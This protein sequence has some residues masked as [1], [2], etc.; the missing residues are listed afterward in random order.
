MYFK[1]PAVEVAKSKLFKFVSGR[2]PP[3]VNS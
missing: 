3:F 2:N 1:K